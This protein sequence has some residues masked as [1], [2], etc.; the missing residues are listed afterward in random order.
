MKRGLVILLLIMIM[1]SN[2]FSY[3]Y[4]REGDCGYQG[5]ISSGETPNSSVYEYKEVCFLTGE[6]VVFTGT[7][8]LKKQSRN[9]EM[10]LTYTYSLNNAQK[11]AT[12]NRTMVYTTVIEEKD[13]GQTVEETILDGRASE[14]VKIGDKSFLLRRYDFTRSELIDHKPAVDFF[15]G[16]VWW[17]KDYT[18]G[19]V[20]DGNS[21][22]VECTGRFYGYEQYWGMTNSAEFNYVIKNMENKEGQTDNWGGNATVKISAS[23][24][25]EFQY[26]ENEPEQI[27]FDG[28]YVQTQVNNYVMEYTSTLPIFDSNGISTDELVERTGSLKLE[29]FPVQTRLPVPDLT[30]LR[31]HWAED[32][33]KRL[34]SLE[35]LVENDSVFDPHKI[36]TRAEF[37]SAFVKA[38]KEVPVDPALVTRGSTTSRSSK[39]IT[40]PFIDVSIE[41]I[42]FDNIK[43]AYERKLV[44]GVG[45]NY[46][47][48]EVPITFADAVTILMRSLGL[49]NLAPSPEPVTIF[50]DND[51]I[52]DYA[53]RPIY[54]AH[55]IGLVKGDD[56]GYVRPLD[57][58][59][60]ARAAAI[61]NRYIDYL[62]NGII[63]DYREGFVNY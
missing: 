51:M 4:A 25:K 22:T 47:D 23:S 52:P 35:I 5:G 7:L 15:A 9:E 55:R 11:E 54:A 38:S 49:E 10:T 1:V 20:T 59:D 31:G 18:I 27:S 13:N 57:N 19:G 36:M 50:K 8:T 58:I 62:R 46:F 3:V 6:P 16:N 29:T 33:V 17:K 61:I 2:L 63:T 60:N 56:L 30:H 21:I 14:T 44:V 40:S 32:D 41:H 37:T 39:E 28:G 53:R 34:Y 45:E 42:Y 43:E 24:T 48:P 26:F 12:L